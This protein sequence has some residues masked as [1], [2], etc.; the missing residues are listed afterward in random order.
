MSHHFTSNNHSTALLLTVILCALLTSCLDASYKTRDELF[1]A[2]QTIRND[3]VEEGLKRLE[4]LKNSYDNG[5]GL[6]KYR[7]IL[8]YMYAQNLMGYPITNDSILERALHFC[9]KNASANAQTKARYLLGC[10]YQDKKQYSMAQQ[11]FLKAVGNA[12]TLAHDSDYGILFHTYLQLGNLYRKEHSTAIAEDTY[13][14]A[15]FY[16]L[17]M[18]DSTKWAKSIVGVASC[19]LQGKEWDECMTLCRA[20]QPYLYRKKNPQAQ[21]FRLNALKLACM[22]AIE[23]GCLEQARTLLDSLKR[24]SNLALSG[25]QIQTIRETIE[26][27]QVKYLIKT[28]QWDAA[29]N[30]VLHAKQNTSKE[31]QTFLMKQTAEIYYATGQKDAAFSLLQSYAERLDSTLSQNLAQEMQQFQHTINKMNAQQQIE[32]SQEQK[33]QTLIG[34]IA[35][36]LVLVGL[37]LGLDFRN[38][39][40]FRIKLERF[41]TKNKELKEQRELLERLK[42]TNETDFKRQIQHL[43][44]RLT[45][46]E[47]ELSGY[48]QQIPPKFVT[49]EM[50]GKFKQAEVCQSI[51]SKIRNNKRVTDEDLRTVY[52]ILPDYLPQVFQ[53]VSSHHEMLQGALFRTLVFTLLQVRGKDIAS[54]CFCEAHAISMNKARINEILFGQ[55]TAKNLLRNLLEAE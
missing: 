9:E 24:Y 38:R 49:E 48:L 46:K 4:A 35:C 45:V 16:A 6:T 22:S 37:F 50:L 20:A 5:S 54:Q 41:T 31:R 19:K 55:H 26:D 8:T 15:G 25:K 51:Q 32:R 13:H 11:W 2:E 18:N 27:C 33:R 30:L 40:R 43:E 47:A 12:D 21:E 29:K 17:K 36:I 39:Q 7:F 44:E 34:C 28:R 14:K 52:D 1:Q 3:S 10:C 53:K 23:T 42:E